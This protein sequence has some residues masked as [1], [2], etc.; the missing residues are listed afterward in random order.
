MWIHILQVSLPVHSLCVLRLPMKGA[1]K[2]FQR[3]LQGDS[4]TAGPLISVNLS[5]VLPKT[6]QA[7]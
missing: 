4:F 2:N 7:V 6:S 5:M 1:A 3:P